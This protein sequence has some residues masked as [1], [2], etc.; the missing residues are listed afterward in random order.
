M[1]MLWGSSGG[2]MMER[3]LKL[4]YFPLEWLYNH[5][6]WVESFYDWWFG[7]WEP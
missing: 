2:R 4:F 1:M 3:F 6:E 7:V 5:V